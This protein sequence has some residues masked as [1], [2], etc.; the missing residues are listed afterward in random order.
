MLVASE[1][2]MYHH[3]K[4]NGSDF[5]K[6]DVLPDF[7]PVYAILDCGTTKNAAQFEVLL[8]DTT[9]LQMLLSSVHKFPKTEKKEFQREKTIEKGKAEEDES[10]LVLGKK[11]TSQIKSP[12]ATKSK[13][14][15]AQIKPYTCI[16]GRHADNESE[17]NK[18]YISL[19][20]TYGGTI[21]IKHVWRKE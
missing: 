14:E 16:F 9:M 19:L 6:I 12:T 1:S 2:E 8:G 17:T 18:I 20:S 7:K 11:Q 15:V 10:M 3:I 21:K 4:P 5:I 13:S